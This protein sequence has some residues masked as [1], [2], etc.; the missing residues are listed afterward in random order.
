MTRRLAATV[1]LVL[2]VLL[3]AGC[4][5]G[6]QSDADSVAR[7][8]ED[9]NS[10]QHGLSL[11]LGDVALAYRQL[12][13][14]SN[15]ETMQPKLEKS[16]ATL[17]EARAARR[18]A[19]ASARGPADGRLHPRPVHGEWELANELALLAAYVHD[20]AP[21]LTRASAA[22][23][24]LRDALQASRTR[25]AQA[26]ALEEY[27][28]PLD[29]AARQVG[30]LARA[31]GRRPVA[32][33]ADQHLPRDCRRA[34]A[35]ATAIAQRKSGAQQVHD[36][37][38]AVASSAP[39]RR[40]RPGSPRSRRSTVESPGYAGSRLWPSASATASSTRSDAVAHASAHP[41]SVAARENGVAASKST[42][43]WDGPG[44]S[45]VLRLLTRPHQS[46]LRLQRE[47]DAL[48]R[49]LACQQGRL[50]EA[51]N[52][53]AGAPDATEARTSAS[54]AGRLL[55]STEATSGQPLVNR[56]VGASCARLVEECCSYPLWRLLTCSGAP[57]RIDK[58]G[59]TGSSP[60]P[61]IKARMVDRH[62]VNHA[63]RVL[64]YGSVV[65]APCSPGC[66]PEDVRRI[67]SHR[68]DLN[69]YLPIARP[70]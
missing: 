7:Y 67:C 39:P 68:F 15:L 43:D 40:R 45:G 55:S 66:T 28:A 25:A 27:A 32:A 23:T 9:V 47:C 61:P 22:G 42:C 59:V 8:I 14:G 13:N 16:V 31:R 6:D 62:P 17:S 5:G 18:R 24:G 37:Q 52:R 1:G 36:L 20:A 56:G 51:R 30:E 35:L 33:H 46:A 50:F 41:R 70:R 38:V 60:V 57:G 11:P 21:V 48:M 63:G 3:V 64:S 19:P 65:T 4:G 34:R 26:D 69:P 53:Q 29:A 10:I 2:L 54:E 12:S 58:L 49:I 44:S